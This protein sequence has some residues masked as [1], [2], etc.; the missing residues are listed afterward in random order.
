MP[1]YCLTLDLKDDPALIAEYER[2]HEAVWPGIRKSILNA[3]ITAMEIYRFDNRLFMIMETD[4]SFS[5]D[6]KGKMDAG[7]AEVQEWETL[8]W[9]YQQ[10]LKNALKGEKWVLMKQIFSL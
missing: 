3:G 7:N 4:N 1:R 5:F 10:P 6:R 8:M 9:N 2:H